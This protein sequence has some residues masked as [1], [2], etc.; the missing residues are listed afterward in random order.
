MKR[1]YNHWRQKELRFN[2]AEAWPAERFPDADYRYFRDCGCLVCALAVMLRHSGTEKEEDESL[3]DPWI[4]NKRLID[5]GAFTPAA[6]LEL[7]CISRLYPL[8]YVG[9]FRMPGMLWFR[10]WNRG[11]RALSPCRENMP[12]DILPRRCSRCRTMCSYLTRSAGNGD[13]ALIRGFARSV[14][15]GR[16]RNDGAPAPKV[17]NIPGMSEQLPVGNLIICRK[18][19]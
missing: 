3:F 15:S 14:Y 11:C 10:S 5:C 1:S 8:E 18:K 6:D 12:T 9:R 17:Q 2:R 7:F 19:G 4:L 13:S 16:K